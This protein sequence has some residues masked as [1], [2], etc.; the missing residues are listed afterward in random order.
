VEHTPE[1]PLCVTTLA[2]IVDFGCVQIASTNQIIDAPLPVDQFPTLGDLLV[3][4][5]D[6]LL[7]LLTCPLRASDRWV[8]SEVSLPI[9]VSR[10][11]KLRAFDCTSTS[12]RFRSARSSTP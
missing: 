10:A 12:L 1:G 5:L 7:R 2:D 11:S 8:S 4:F 9:R 3:F 6:R